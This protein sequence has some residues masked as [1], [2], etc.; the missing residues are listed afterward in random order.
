M[1]VHVPLVLFICTVCIVAEL[2]IRRLVDLGKDLANMLQCKKKYKARRFLEKLATYKDYM[3]IVLKNVDE[4]TIRGKKY[5]KALEK[6][7]GPPLLQSKIEKSCITVMMNMTIE[8][9][10]EVESVINR[11][12]E[13]WNQIQ[14]IYANRS[15]EEDTVA[16]L[17]DDFKIEEA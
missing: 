3:E 12:R 11:T 8:K 2:D 4:F 10:E 6:Q 9:V 17:V 15:H 16:I 14:S 13:L 7:N 5:F 1:R